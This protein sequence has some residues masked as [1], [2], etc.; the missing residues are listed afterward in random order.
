MLLHDFN[1]DQV[2]V[3]DFTSWNAGGDDDGVTHFE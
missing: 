1:H 3:A 2:G